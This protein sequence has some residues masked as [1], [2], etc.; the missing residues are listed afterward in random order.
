MAGRHPTPKPSP[1]VKAMAKTIENRD[2]EI[3]DLQ[4]E[5]SRLRAI[6][7]ELEA[8]NDSLEQKGNRLVHEYSSAR[9]E[10]EELQ[11]RVKS[12]SQHTGVMRNQ[13]D[14]EDVVWEAET[15]LHSYQTSLKGYVAFD[16]LLAFLTTGA[17]LGSTATTG[18]LSVTLLVIAVV[19]VAAFGLIGF[20]AA[21]HAIK[22]IPEAKRELANQKRI[23]DRITLREAGFL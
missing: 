21:D 23:L 7:R 1:P 17:F 9:R 5:L 14:Q 22:Q 15:N 20:L 19:L 3:A 8:Y 6:N 10:I 18:A 4:H 13:Q 11:V 12:A 2:L 16:L